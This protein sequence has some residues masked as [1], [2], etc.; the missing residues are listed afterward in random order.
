MASNLVV[1]RDILGWADG[2]KA[3]LLKTYESIIPVGG[4]T[5]PQRSADREVAIFCKENDCDLLTGDAKAY[6]HYF[7]A[8]IPAV[9]IFQYDWDVR[10]G[11]PVLL[12]QIID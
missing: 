7:Q 3:R 6:L 8:K 9:R 4:D 12:I 2:Q 5:L 10:G 11:K 1:D